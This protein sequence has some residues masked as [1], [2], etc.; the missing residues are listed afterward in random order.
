MVMLTQE[1]IDSLPTIT[2]EEEMC[3]YYVES[4]FEENFKSLLEGLNNDVKKIDKK[5]GH[6]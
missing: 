4:H 1:F 2:E 3:D 6:R 5:Y